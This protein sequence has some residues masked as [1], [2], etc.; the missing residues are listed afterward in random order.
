[1]YCNIVTQKKEAKLKQVAKKQEQKM[2]NSEVK[3]K[4]AVKKTTTTTRKKS[5]AT[6]VKPKVD[7]VNVTEVKRKRGRPRKVQ[8]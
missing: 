8:E 4:E 2:K 7:E 6:T 3:E 1:M 5:T